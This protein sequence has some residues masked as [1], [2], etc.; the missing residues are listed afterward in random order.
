MKREMQKN[1]A[2]LLKR[3]D[4]VIIGIWAAAALCLFLLSAF[5]TRDTEKAMM[6]EI[7][8]GK[9]IFGI[10]SLDEDRTIDIGSGNICEIKN[11]EVKMT[12]ADCPDR[13]CLHSKAISG[14]GESIVC[15]PNHVIL[16]ITGE[17][18]G[19]GLDAVSE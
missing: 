11:G 5:G 18:E 3:S 1:R 14:M 9:E 10:Y 7:T 8:V 15:L 19:G 13:I 2:V 12:Y 16:K 17:E 4:I 6:L